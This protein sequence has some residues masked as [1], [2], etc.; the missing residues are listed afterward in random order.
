M[1]FDPPGG[2]LFTLTALTEI[3][4]VPIQLLLLQGG[5]A[6][7]DVNIFRHSSY[8]K[9]LTKKQNKNSTTDSNWTGLLF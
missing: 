1:Q 5:E 9:L 6:Y 4:V 7:H 8:Y 3:T 2:T